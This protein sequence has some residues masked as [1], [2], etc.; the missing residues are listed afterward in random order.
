MRAIERKCA[1]IFAAA[2][3]NRYIRNAAINRIH[4]RLRERT[5]GDKSASCPAGVREENIT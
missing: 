3:A 4:S 2:I 5:V 1:D